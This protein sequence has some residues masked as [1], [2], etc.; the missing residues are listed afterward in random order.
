MKPSRKT[1]RGKS[2]RSEKKREPMIVEVVFP[3]P[4]EE[5][6]SDAP[7]K[8]AASADR[9]GSLRPPERIVFRF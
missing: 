5:E 2:V 8:S 4:V 7:A 9:S 1:R 3:D 6:T